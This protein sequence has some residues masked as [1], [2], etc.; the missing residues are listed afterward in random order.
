M[1]IRILPTALTPEQKRQYEE[2]QRAEATRREERDRRVSE[3][4]AT[5]DEVA[6]AALWR[7]T[8][9]EAQAHGKYGPT[10]RE[11]D[12][13]RKL[14]RGLA[15][16]VADSKVAKF[17]CLYEPALEEAVRDPHLRGEVWRHPT[18][19]S[20]N[21]KATAI[22]SEIEIAAARRAGAPSD[23]P[24]AAKGAG[25]A[26]KRAKLAR[27]PKERRHHIGKWD[28]RLMLHLLLQRANEWE[29]A[30]RDLRH[31]GTTDLCAFLLRKHSAE[32]TKVSEDMIRPDRIERFTALR[33]FFQKHPLGTAPDALL[34]GL[35]KSEI[36]AALGKGDHPG[37]I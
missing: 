16:V 32:V 37:G 27:K 17:L 24:P 4:I 18:A 5:Q 36:D 1:A 9:G 12:H 6:M 28:R 35:D 29:D 13:L 2:R 10:D 19:A 30:K 26:S 34:V 33:G 8:M 15:I 3:A 23:A 22:V 20:A 31:M 7:V 14:T 21:A 11:L 25:E